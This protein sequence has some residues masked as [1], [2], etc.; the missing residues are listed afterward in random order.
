MQITHSHT[1]TE[2]PNLN[3]LPNVY[4]GVLGQSS[5]IQLSFHLRHQVVTQSSFY[6]LWLLL[7][8]NLI[9]ENISDLPLRLCWCVDEISGS[10]FIS[11]L[12]VYIYSTV[13]IS[14]YIYIHTYSNDPVQTHFF[15]IYIKKSCYHWYR[16]LVMVM[17]YHY[18]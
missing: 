14:I 6:K 12:K 15:K 8:I 16:H 5:W 1:N 2:M 10:S 13:Y 4:G 11:K 17:V 7:W 3:W 9:W 18:H